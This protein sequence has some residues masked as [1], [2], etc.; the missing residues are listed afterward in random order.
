MKQASYID[1]IKLVF[2]KADA[3]DVYIWI[4]IFDNLIMNV[5]MGISSIDTCIWGMFPSKQKTVR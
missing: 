1:G 3:F 5:V 2:I 4:R